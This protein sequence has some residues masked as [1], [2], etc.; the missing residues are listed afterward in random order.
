MDVATM[1]LI[2]LN[3]KYSFLDRDV[4]RRKLILLTFAMQVMMELNQILEIKN[5]GFDLT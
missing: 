4:T 1:F 5:F 3:P 2:L